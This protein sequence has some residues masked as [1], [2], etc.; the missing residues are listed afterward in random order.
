MRK[1]LASQLDELARGLR[2]DIRMREEGE[3]RFT[4]CQGLGGG[5]GCAA[6]RR[7]MKSEVS[8]QY[9]LLNQCQERDAGLFKTESP[10]VVRRGQSWLS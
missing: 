8:Q 5:F 1:V 10:S 9:A 4:G 2:A 7:S 3:G 6:A